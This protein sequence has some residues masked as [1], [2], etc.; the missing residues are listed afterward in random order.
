MLKSYVYKSNSYEQ[1]KIKVIVIINASVAVRYRPKIV[2]VKVTPCC[3][4]LCKQ[5]SSQHMD[6]GS[7]FLMHD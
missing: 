5:A 7:I 3:R 6:I 1:Y 2:S 4:I